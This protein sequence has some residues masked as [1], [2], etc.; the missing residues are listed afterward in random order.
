MS[1]IYD[2]WVMF[3][4]VPRVLLYQAGCATKLTTHRS[5]RLLFFSEGSSC[6]NCLPLAGHILTKY[7]EVRERSKRM[8]SF[9]RS[10]IDFEDCND[11]FVDLGSRFRGRLC[12]PWR[13]NSIEQSKVS[14][15]HCALK[16]QI[17]FCYFASQCNITS[18]TCNVYDKSSPGAITYSLYWTLHGIN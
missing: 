15:E 12:R 7:A 16:M 6:W 10:E 9:H 8:S 14:W 3:G 17:N 18:L 11:R 1:P 2:F 5:Y 13:S 4:F